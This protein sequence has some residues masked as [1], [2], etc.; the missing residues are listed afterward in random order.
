VHDVIGK[1]LEMDPKKVFF[2]IGLI[3]QRMKLPKIDFPKRPLACTPDQLTAVQA[4][5][6]PYLP[7]PPIGIHKIIAKQLKMD[8]WRVHVAIKLIRKSRN[9][10]R[11]N[12]DR[13]DLPEEV[14]R[15]I[16]EQLAEG[17]KLRAAA[18]EEAAR[19]AAEQA[20]QPTEAV[21]AVEVAAQVVPAPASPRDDSLNNDT[22]ASAPEPAVVEAPALAQPKASEPTEPEASSEA[23]SDEA[24]AP[25]KRGRPKKDATPDA[26]AEA[27]VNAP[28]ATDEAEGDEAPAP[29][30]RG[31]PK[32]V[33][34]EPV[35]EADEREAVTQPN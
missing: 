13:T 7:E 9:L 2:A 26:D 34:E 27:T 8:E 18:A 5:Y 23:D 30:K 1:Q 20:A 14:M 6:E 28:V 31:R 12:E 25:K 21:A 11:W 3:R 32:K 33:V 16:K 35:A 10:P 15:H 4:L 22:Q 19:V 29:K 17:V 24:P